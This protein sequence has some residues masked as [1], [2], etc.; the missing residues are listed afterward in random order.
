[1]SEETKDTIKNNKT[2]KISK[3]VQS[4]KKPKK[5]TSFKEKITNLKDAFFNPNK[6]GDITISKDSISKK[7]NTTDKSKTKNKI[8]ENTKTKNSK[9]NSQI[10]KD[11]ALASKSTKKTTKPTKPEIIEYYDLPY[12]YNQ[13]VIKTLYQT[14]STLFVYW[15]ISDSD[16]E[17]FKKQY[18]ENFFETT[19]P[20]LIITNTTMNYKFEIEINDFAN[21]WYFKVN[22]SKC[23]Y[24]IE[25]GRR[26]IYTNQIEIK[27]NYIYVTSSNILETPNDKILFTTNEN[28]TVLFR[29]VKTNQT[30]NISLEKIFEK[31]RN[32]DDFQNFP[33]IKNLSGMFNIKDLYKSLYKETDVDNLYSSSNPSS[34]SNPSSSSLTS[35]R[36]TY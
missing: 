19:K 1:M 33:L 24:R 18:G 26:P 30:Q 23:N 28:N 29:N 10:K 25:L 21:S 17:N 14:P 8:S 3:N 20:V 12:R 27:N 35:S 16:R 15:D 5:Q 4:T 6:S 32:F 9:K 31:A 7:T 34:G 22:D 11:T 2:D 36:V 13:T